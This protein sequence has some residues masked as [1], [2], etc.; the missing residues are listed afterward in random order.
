MGFGLFFLS[1][2]GGY[3]FNRWCKL[4]SYFIYRDTGYNLLFKSAST[5]AIL[6]II[7]YFIIQGFNLSQ[8]NIYE[9]ERNLDIPKYTILSLLSFLLGPILST[10]INS[11]SKIKE[12]EKKAIYKSENWLEYYSENLLKMDY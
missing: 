1:L 12:I 2:L 8:Y 4:T 10:L 5:G 7:S 11:L 3:I 9:L 6:A